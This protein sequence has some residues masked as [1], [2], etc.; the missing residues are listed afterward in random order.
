MPELHVVA[1][2]NGHGDADDVH[3]LA[4]I[5]GPGVILKR[6]HYLIVQSVRLAAVTMLQI[7]SADQLAP[8]HSIPECWKLKAE[9]IDA[10]VEVRSELTIVDSICERAVGRRYQQYVH[11][12]AFRGAHR[13]HFP[14]LQNAQ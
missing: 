2:G 7:D 6:R 3:Q 14:F 13:C 9:A 8:V 5:A 4:N 11:G 10:V 1:V 12:N